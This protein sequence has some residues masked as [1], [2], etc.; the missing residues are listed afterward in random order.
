MPL[1]IPRLIFEPFRQWPSL[2][3]QAGA[4]PGLSA[5]D[6]LGVAAAGDVK[7]RAV[8]HFRSERAPLVRAQGPQ[9]AEMDQCARKPRMAVEWRKEGSGNRLKDNFARKTF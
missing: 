1:G 6:A 2:R 4:L 7:E 9:R 3:I 8:T 5:T